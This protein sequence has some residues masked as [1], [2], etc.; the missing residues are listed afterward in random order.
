MKALVRANKMSIRT[1]ANGGGRVF[2]S[3]EGGPRAVGGVWTWR[4]PFWVGAGAMPSQQAGPDANTLDYYLR[5]P[6]AV[7]PL[8]ELFPP[9]TSAPPDCASLA[10]VHTAT[11]CSARHPLHRS[12]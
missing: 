1:L 3:R 6:F 5:S 9:P 11:S 7:P 8:V 4:S 2:W 12:P 10:S